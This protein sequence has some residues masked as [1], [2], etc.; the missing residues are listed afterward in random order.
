MAITPTILPTDTPHPFKRVNLSLPP[1][2]TEFELVGAVRQLF[3]RARQARRPLVAQWQKN[4]RMLRTRTWV[5]G[6][7]EW[8]PAPEVPEIYPIVTSM[9]GWM[10]DQRPVLECTPAAVPQTQFYE[11]V[12]QIAQ[13]LQSALYS[14]WITQRWDSAVEQVLWD[15]WT[16][17]TGIFKCVWDNALD[18]GIGN[19]SMR[20]VDP[21]T[22]YPDPQGSSMETCNYFIEARTMSMQE[23]DRRWPGSADALMAGQMEDID[24][25]PQRAD[26]P[27]ST[28][29]AQPGAISP[30]TSPRYGSPGASRLNVNSVEAPGVTVFEC[31]IREHEIDDDDPDDILIYDCWRVIV[32]AGNRV[33]M[34]ERADELWEH[35]RHPYVRYVAHETG[36]LWGLSMVEMLA[37]AQLA[38]NRLLAALQNQIE[39][40]GNPIFLEGARSGLQRQSF[41]NKPG[42]RHTVNE[43]SKAEWLQPPPVHPMMKELITFYINEME[44]I[45][46]LSAITRGSAPQ[47]RNSQGVLDSVQEASFVRIRLALR[48][49]EYSLR[50]VGELLSSLIVEYYDTPRFV[51]ILGPDGEAMS[52]ALK[53]KHFYVPGPNGETPFRYSLMVSAG[54]EQSTSPQARRSDAAQLLALGAL[55]EQAVLE[56]F[57][58]PNRKQVL[59]RVNALKAAGVMNPPGKRERAR[60]A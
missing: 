50:E 38:I 35:A 13:D 59:A 20:R 48:N 25:A 44:R 24:V 57:N 5:S 10:T 41:V 30:A 54:S 3:F 58:W 33:L 16:Y 4:Y 9:V 40:T 43:N 28:P 6:R 26:F 29:R 8:M 31:W 27:Q 52:R 19:A 53:A 17:G 2:G 60:A 7:P 55:D 39:L 22:W 23:V 12:S 56:A 51:A 49:L 47:G 1:G 18:K 21:F 34:D 32:V 14:A 37:P 45:S 36:E 42:T 11:L 15:A 46:G